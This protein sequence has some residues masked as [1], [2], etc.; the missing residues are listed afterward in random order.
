MKTESMKNTDTPSE[1][2]YRKLEKDLDAL[3]NQISYLEKEDHEAKRLFDR[4]SCLPEPSRSRATL[5]LD[6][7]FEEVLRSDREIQSKQKGIL[8]KRQKLPCPKDLR[9]GW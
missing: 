8:R 2:K 1:A 3:S 7:F 6:M 4:V 5:L 9:V